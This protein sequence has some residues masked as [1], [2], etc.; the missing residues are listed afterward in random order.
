MNIEAGNEINIEVEYQKRVS[1]MTPREKIARMALYL[2]TLEPKPD[3]RPDAS[4]FGS[5]RGISK[6]DL[7]AKTAGIIDNSLSFSAIV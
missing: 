3:A 1:E 7:S 2:A 6:T 4:A 5:D